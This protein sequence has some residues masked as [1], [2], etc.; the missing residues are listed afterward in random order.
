[1]KTINTDKSIRS[2]QILGFAS[3]A[4][5]LGLFGA[6]TEFASLNGAVIAPATI[7]AES[8]S[9]KVQ[10]REGG[11]VSRILIKDGDSVTE[12]QELV[13]LDPTEIKS[14]LG[15]VQ[16]QLNELYIKKARLTA[17]RDGTETFDL[18]IDLKAFANDAGVT[19]ILSG[20]RHLLEST[21]QGV[22]SKKDQLK[23]QMGQ[24]KDQIGGV[25]A[26]INSDKRQMVLITSELQSLRS[27]QKQGLV[28]VSRV[29]AMEREAARLDG[30]QG[31]LVASKAS[32]EAKMS[33]TKLQIIQVDEDLRNM[34]LTDLRDVDSKIGEL[35]QRK[36]SA[37]ARLSRMSI[38]APISGTIYQLAVHT[39]GGVVAPG[40]TLMMIVPKGDDL[41]LQAQVTPNDIDNVHTGQTAKIKFN[42]FNTR[43]TMDINAEVSQVAA[44]TTRVDAQSAPF[45]LIRLTINADELAKLG[46]NKLKPGM[47]AEAFIQTEAR[48]PLSYL[49]QPL[50]DQFS[51]AMRES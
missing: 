37:S 1:M 2:T 15:I 31:Q 39:E 3:F 16:N 33:E 48:T 11:N 19:E 46:D 43:T 10:H 36:L 29:S 38:K 47:S 40:E 35:E 13:L 14:E 21:L 5:M 42:A 9:K 20:Q 44:D 6:W 30:E 50:M 32:A 17:Q 24:I 49:I 8:Y 51:H 25:V 34:S 4:V 41:V 27:L 45:Y 23:Q 22:T 7:V 26:Q 18:P 28:P 12:G